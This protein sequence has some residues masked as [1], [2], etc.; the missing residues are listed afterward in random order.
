MSDQEDTNGS[1]VSFREQDMYLPITNVARIMKNA[2]PQTGKIAK[3][4]KECVQE[5]V[6]ELISFITSEAS[7]RCHREKQKT[8]NGEDTLFAMCLDSYVKP[9]KLY[10]Q[11][12]RE[13]MK[14]EKGVSGAVTATGGLSEE[15]TEEAFTNQIPWE[16]CGPAHHLRNLNT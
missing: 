7:E 6:S 11:N 4:A 3:D 5:C 1:K 14:G 2:I 10:L 13:A 15:L 9:L 8:I 16:L 12:F